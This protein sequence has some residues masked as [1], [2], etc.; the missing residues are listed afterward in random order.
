M[1]DEMKAIAS[2]AAALEPLELDQR[3]RILRWAKD[4]YEDSL[5][6]IIDREQMVAVKAYVEEVNRYA[7]SLGV[8]PRAL[9]HT[10][11]ALRERKVGPIEVRKELTAAE[12]ELLKGSKAAA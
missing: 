9:I 2:V 8:E 7:K 6:R 4:K 10:F 12:K 5:E 11:S 1:A 3:T